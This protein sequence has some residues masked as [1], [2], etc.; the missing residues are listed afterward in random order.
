MPWAGRTS[1]CG[2]SCA[3]RAGDVHKYR[4]CHGYRGFGNFV[5]FRGGYHSGD[6]LPA[7]GDRRNIPVLDR[8]GFG[9]VKDQSGTGETGADIGDSGGYLQEILKLSED[10]G[11]AFDP[12]MGKVIRLW[13][14]GGGNAGIPDEAELKNL[15]AETGYENLIL[16]GDEAELQSGSLDLGAVGKGIG[17][18]AVMEFLEEQEGVSGMLMN[19]GGSSVMVYGEKPDGSHWRVAV[20]D[21]RDDESG[22]LGALTLKGG[23]FLSTSGDYEKYFIEDGKRYHHILDPK[24]GYPAWNG[25]TSVTVVCGSGLLADGLSTA[26]FVLG[27]EDALPLLEKYGAEA[28]FVDEDHNVYLT[29]GMKERFELLKNTYTIQETAG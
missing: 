22:F 10:S 11:G 28:V 20:R 7:P 17:C 12:T 5:Y 18:D 9:S 14:I 25:L 3:G 1:V 23:E 15:L 24:T 13:D 2:N 21:P 4:F 26:C 27:R 29:D 6:R 19:L 8:W 16:D